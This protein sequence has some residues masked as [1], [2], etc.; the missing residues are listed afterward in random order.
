MTASIFVRWLVLIIS[1]I[2]C[3]ECEVESITVA[4]KVEDASEDERMMLTGQTNNSRQAAWV[5]FGTVCSYCFTLLS[6]VILSRYFDKADYG[7]YQQVLY[8]YH[9][10]LSVFTLGLPRAYSYFLPR[11]K[12]GEAKDVINKINALFFGLGLLFSSLLYVF[13][14]TIAV[15]LKNPD[16]TN[17]LRIFSP[18]PFLML[19][20]MGIQGVLATYRKG[21]LVALYTIVSRFLM[22]LFVAIP[23]VFGSGTYIEAII[24]FTVAAFFD[25]FL[26]MYLKYYPVRKE[27]KT[28]S[29][30]G[31]NSILKFAIPLLYASIWGILITSADQF[32]ISHYFG[33]SV[34]AEFSNGSIELP[35]VTMIIGTCSTV[36]SPVFSRLSHEKVDPKKE[37]Y[38]LWM[39]VYTKTVM[40]VYPLLV[41][42]W[43]FAD[44]IM[45]FLFGEQYEN[46]AIY[47]RIKIIAN[48]FN[49][50]I[51]APLLINVGK[52]RLYSNVHMMNAIA[53][54]LLELLVV[55][56]CNSP[57]M[58]SIVSL[59]CKLGTIFILLFAVAKFFGVRF[60]QLFPKSVMVKIL[61]P[62]F[63]FLYVVH[64]L[65]CNMFFLNTIQILIISAVTYFVCYLLYSKWIEL[66]YLKI[67]SPL[68]SKK[69]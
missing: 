44:T 62:S 24:G 58:V 3:W 37:I 40:L 66:D 54:I 49:L 18:V 6:S 38:P 47:F 31:Y 56:I 52:V 69:K 60:H 39:S 32:F 19:P 45:V 4:C 68:L 1:N 15:F 23:V 41:Y 67:V 65:L 9:T 51:F 11:V 29:D 17:A 36:L 30:V 14:P 22:L 27:P 61:I 7:T 48:L 34:F 43:V 53:V 5:A 21:H 64:Y 59:I 57:Y 46:S 25:F 26:A 35:F 50:I 33:T 20:T 2:R 13:A 10:L 8:V 42:C 28:R 63:C 12:G 16:L 55:T